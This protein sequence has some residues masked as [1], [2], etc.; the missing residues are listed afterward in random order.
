MRKTK[1]ILVAAILCILVVYAKSYAHNWVCI[2]PGHGGSDPG[3]HG[4]V[5]GVLEKDVNLGVGIMAFSYLVY[6]GWAPIMTR[7]IDTTLSREIRADRANKANNGV[8]VN[9]FVCIHHNAADTIPVPDTITNGTETFW[10]NAA[11]TDSNLDRNITDTLARKVYYRLR[12]QFHYPERGFKLNCGERFKILRLTKMAS[13]LSEA[14]FLTCAAVERKFYY[15]FNEECGKEGE[16]IFHGC[17]SYLRGFGIVTI[18]YA[19]A[20]GYD[21]QV[22]IDY[23][24]TVTTPFVTCWEAS[25]THFLTCKGTMNWA[26]HTYTFNHWN[27]EWGEV[28]HDPYQCWREPYYDTTWYICMP[29]EHN[30]NYYAYMTGG[31]FSVNV[32]WPNGWEIWHI[33]EQRYIHWSASPG[34]DS[35]SKVDIYLSRDGGSNWTSIANDLPYDF[36]YGGY[37]LWTVTD[38]VSTH[39]RIKS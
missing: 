7:D 9:A 34:A 30:H 12:D 23:A 14:S 36:D 31:P 27:H 4:R 11:K 32:I 10:C 15:N 39:C 22:I 29:Y 17:S 25:E 6:Y 13:T 35:S 33:G 2:D 18:T 8:G 24:D 16:A 38:P 3:T 21:G 1:K 20:G 37:Y 28:P 19:Y 5:Y 26:G